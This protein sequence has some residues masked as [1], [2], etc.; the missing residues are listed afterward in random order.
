MTTSTL[1]SSTG[2]PGH[3][4]DNSLKRSFDLKNCAYFLTK[5][6]FHL[7]LTSKKEEGNISPDELRIKK[8]QN[9]GWVDLPATGSGVVGEYD[10][11]LSPNHQMTSYSPYIVY[12]DNEF[13]GAFT[14]KVYNGTDWVQISDLPAA[15]P[16]SSSRPNLAVNSNVRSMFLS[17]EDDQQGSIPKILER[18]FY[19]SLGP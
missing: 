11:V 13:L 19:Y 2:L 10:I 1:K 6:E 7:F 14:A 3:L 5:L 16:S 4:W 8:L 18:E 15:T 9:N 12:K 17:F